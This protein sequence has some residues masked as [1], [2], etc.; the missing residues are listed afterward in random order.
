[1]P[2]GL[3]AAGLAVLLASLDRLS[4]TQ[5]VVSSN[6][7]KSRTTTGIS[8][9]GRNSRTAGDRWGTNRPAVMTIREVQETKKPCDLQGFSEA[10]DGTRTHDLLHGKQTL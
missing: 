7:P 4:R 8:S 3:S 2:C 6:G 10:A 5:K 1:M 9:S